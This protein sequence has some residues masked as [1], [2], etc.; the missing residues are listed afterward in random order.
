[1]PATRNRYRLP[2]GAVD[3]A[4]QGCLAAMAQ[5]RPWQTLPRPDAG[6]S[7]KTADDT[8]VTE[9]DRACARAIRQVLTRLTPNIPQT[10]EELGATRP[11]SS[12]R[13]RW[14]VD[15]IDGTKPFT[16]GLGSETHIVS[17]YDSA[18]SEV[19]L[20]VIGHAASGRI[21]VAQKDRRTYVLYTDGHSKP[22]KKLC[23]VWTGPAAQGTHL[24]DQFSAPFAANGGTQEVWT[25]EGMA[26]F[27]GG[28]VRHR[29][30]VG[31]TG[32]NGYNYVLML[33]PNRTTQPKGVMS[34]LTA[35]QG[36]PWDPAFALGIIG[37][38]GVAQGYKVVSP[39]HLARCKAVDPL[40]TDMVLVAR[41]LGALNAIEDCI[42]LAF[43]V[44]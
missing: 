9:V 16:F 6:G 30:D 43:T 15:P 20:T 1:M 36:G 34:A 21:W 39:G 33:D 29:I 22:I 8:V 37:A 44:V 27:L 14:L 25:R 13:H 35:A 18:I 28:L 17:L 32:S 24:Q 42:K 23:S 5:T 4:V 2:Q 26:T 19:V 7:L 12:R 11:A 31:G 38:G 41:D 3:A 40:G 10:D